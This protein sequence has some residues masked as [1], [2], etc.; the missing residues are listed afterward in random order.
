MDSQVADTNQERNSSDLSHLDNGEGNS[1]ATGQIQVLGPESGGALAVRAAFDPLSAMADEWL[2]RARLINVTSIEQ[3]EDMAFARESRLGLR[4]VRSNVEHL[5]KELKA[6][7]LVRGRTIDST[8]A[9]LEDK[10]LPVETHLREQEEFAIRYEAARLAGIRE[11]RA[12]ELVALGTDPKLYTDLAAVSDDGYAQILAI[13][14]AAHNAKAEAARRA[15]VARLEAERLA[16]EAREADRLERVRLDEERAERE[17][18]QAEENAR[19]KAEAVEREKVVEAE[20][21]ERARQDAIR[22]EALRI[23]REAAAAIAKAEREERD[24]ERQRAEAAAQIER[25][26]AEAQARKAREENERVLRA[27]REAREK[28]EADARRAREEHEAVIERLRV[29]QE[30]DR[31]ERERVE[32]EREEA[33]EKARH[34]AAAAPDRE[35]LLAYAEALAAVPQPVLATTA[36]LSALGKIVEQVLKLVAGIRRLAGGL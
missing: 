18:L 8:A 29:A 6:D 13:A 17:R 12:A 36:G 1:P 25:E 10:I 22:E 34:E 27:E 9:A 26:R 16:A 2:E 32:R 35:K 19:L 20:R 28:I 30:K 11:A 14:R 33:E 31:D 15:E 24:R 5:R 21:A 23:E 3:V 4:K 7:L